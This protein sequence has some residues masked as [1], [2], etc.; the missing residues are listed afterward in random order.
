MAVKSLERGEQREGSFHRSP[1]LVE[2][3]LPEK[4]GKEKRKIGQKDR[5]KGR[6]GNE[7]VYP[8]FFLD[9]CAPCGDGKKKEKRGKGRT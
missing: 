5:K 7:L 9:H 6:V 1:R 2:D 4:E 3:G 8:L